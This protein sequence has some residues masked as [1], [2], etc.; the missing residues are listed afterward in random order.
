[1]PGESRPHLRAPIVKQFIVRGVRVQVWAAM[2]GAF[3]V[4]L[5]KKIR[6]LVDQTASLP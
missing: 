1:M 3:I 5:P 6:T 2:I 4:I